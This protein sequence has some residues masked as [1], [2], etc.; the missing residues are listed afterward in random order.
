MD[1]V[2]IS[3]QQNDYTFLTYREFDFSEYLGT[4]FS[5]ELN[6]Y[7]T[8]EIDESGNPFAYHNRLGKIELISVQENYLTSKNR[9]FRTLKFIR[10]KENK[11]VGFQVSNGGVINLYFEKQE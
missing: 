2:V 4:Y 6:T 5:R 7:Y 9:N 3:E 10:N 8:I 1:K 11:I